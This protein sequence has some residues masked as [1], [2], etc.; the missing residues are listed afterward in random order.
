MLKKI[1]RDILILLGILVMAASTS[2]TFVSWIHEERV[3]KDNWWGIYK[4]I[5]GDLVEM[6]YLDRISK[7]R[8]PRDYTFKKHPVEEGKLNLFL[9]GD[10][11]VW[12]IPDS[13]YAAVKNFKF[14]WRYRDNIDYNLDSSQR[15]ILIIEIAE[16]YV[17]TYFADTDIFWHVRKEQPASALSGNEPMLNMAGF[18]LPELECL[19]NEHINQNLEFNLFNYNFINPIRHTKA[20]LNYYLFSRASG[21]VVLSEDKDQLFLKETVKGKK[22]ENSYYPVNDE[23]VKQI[24][25]TM[26]TIYDHYKEEGFDEIYLSIIPNPATIIQNQGYNQLI[27]RI[28]NNHQLKMKTISVYDRFQKEA[29]KVYRPGDTHWNNHGLQLWLNQVNEMLL[30]EDTIRRNP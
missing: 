4:P 21:D 11:Y 17:R 2:R 22:P 20:S 24:I 16:R 29:G 13:A 28:E 7:F 1:G 15:N 26:N 9:W 25:S 5:E 14:G 23:E 12:K 18:S 10:S 3:E 19:F 6:A 27:P 8:S 30:R